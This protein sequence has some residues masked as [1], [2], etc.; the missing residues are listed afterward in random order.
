M[1][2]LIHDIYIE[3]IKHCK[4]KDYKKLKNVNKFF[5]YYTEKFMK[6][7]VFKK[8]LQNIKCNLLYKKENPLLYLVCGNMKHDVTINQLINNN[9]SK[10]TLISTLIELNIFCVSSSSTFVFTNHGDI[11]QSF[12]ILGKNIKKVE[13]YI[14]NQIVYK[15]WYL[16]ANLINIQPFIEGIFL[17]CLPFHEVRLKIYAD[18]SNKVYGY[19][20]YLHNNIRL[21]L[22]RNTHVI[23]YT[24]Y[25]NINKKLYNN[26]IYSN[27]M[28]ILN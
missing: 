22:A 10:T 15:C 16:N 28:L 11:I 17:I 8:H 6:I 7:K 24:F 4:M 21:H 9:I 20:K 23:P 25:D 26:I 14:G 3:I 18:E 2:L 12:T 1:T 13:L 19:Y 5:R 27:G